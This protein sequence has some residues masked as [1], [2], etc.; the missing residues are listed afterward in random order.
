MIFNFFSN[1][2]KRYEKRAEEDF[3]KIKNIYCQE[4]NFAIICIDV[5]ESFVEGIYP[6]KK[7]EILIKYINK[8]IK[9]CEQNKILFLDIKFKN[10]YTQVLKNNKNIYVKYFDGV[11]DDDILK[12]QILKK[13][14]ENKIEVLYIIGL[15]RTACVLK[16]IFNFLKEE[17]YKIIT[18]FLGTGT[19]KQ[20][21]DI[22][23][24]KI[25]HN[26][27]LIFQAYQKMYKVNGID[28]ISLSNDI[29][30]LVKNG[31]IILDY[32]GE[33]KD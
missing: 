29:K 5:Q 24:S 13:L 15:N 21:Y 7:K 28:K 9:L 10:P 17:K 16:T 30:L 22:Y 2:Y 4:K 3:S 11:L 26:V 18:S 8:L 6:E 1:K 33:D 32:Y 20:T 14:E 12:P 19:Y 27:S 25:K 31:V 23:N